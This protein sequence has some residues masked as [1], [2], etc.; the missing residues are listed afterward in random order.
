MC[1]FASVCVRAWEWR[2]REAGYIGVQI[3]GA[4]MYVIWGGA[5]M[6]IIS[7]G[8]LYRSTHTLTLRFSLV[9]FRFSCRITHTLLYVWISGKLAR[10]RASDRAMRRRIHV[11][12][13]RRAWECGVGVW[14]LVRMCVC[15]CDHSGWR[16]IKTKT[17]SSSSSQNPVHE[18]IRSVNESAPRQRGTRWPLHITRSSRC[19]RALYIRRWACLGC[20]A[21]LVHT[22]L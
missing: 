19:V 13:M 11:C 8:G 22:K 10:E 14:Q 17:C 20:G 7:G 5:Y 12:H 18:W 4:Y 16:S 2:A 3:W 1:V 15:V 21:A 9:W 6:Y